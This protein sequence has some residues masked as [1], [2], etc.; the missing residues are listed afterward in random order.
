[1]AK[2]QV[3]GNAV[4]FSSSMKMEDLVKIQKYN[5]QALTLKDED[6]EVKFICT[7]NPGTLGCVTNDMVVFGGTSNDD[8]KVATV[9]MLLEKEY[10]PDALKEMLAD[11][12][13]AA[14]TCMNELEKSLPD[15]LK[16]VNE[17]RA[18]VMGAISLA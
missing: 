12:I 16:K 3:V 1:M 6:D 18:A 15:V 9:T 11:K 13:G 17:D 7:T 8:K 5:S 14:M 10:E 4:V 2:I